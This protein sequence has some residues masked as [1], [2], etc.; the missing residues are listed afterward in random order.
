MQKYKQLDLQD[1]HKI[2]ALL[3]AG[4]SQTKIAEIIGVHKS[5]IS[6]ELS[7]KEPEEM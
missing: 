3:H 4:H 1:R 2:N 6:R 5:T 7:R